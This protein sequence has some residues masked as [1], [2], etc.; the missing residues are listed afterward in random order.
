MKKIQSPKRPSMLEIPNPS[1]M[2]DMLADGQV[3]GNLQQ[4]M[5]D[6]NIDMNTCDRVRA[7]SMSCKHVASGRYGL[8]PNAYNH[9]RIDS[10]SKRRQLQR[11]NVKIRKKNLNKVEL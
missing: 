3:L 6:E 10:A 9:I 7:L 1:S 2:K 8:G 5:R 4:R 11:L